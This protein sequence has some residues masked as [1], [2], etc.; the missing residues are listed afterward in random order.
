MS[1]LW[2]IISIS[3][4]ELQACKLSFPGEFFAFESIFNIISLLLKSFVDSK[5]KSDKLNRLSKTRNL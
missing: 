1:D 4:P 5:L 2:G 3:M